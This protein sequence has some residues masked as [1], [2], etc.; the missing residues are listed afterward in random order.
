MALTV[1]TVLPGAQYRETGELWA[2]GGMN[3]PQKPAISPIEG[4]NL[5][6]VIVEPI[7]SVV[8]WANDNGQADCWPGRIN[9]QKGGKTGSEMS[10][11]TGS[12][13]RVG[14]STSPTLK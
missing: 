13:G 5:F 6:S 10:F 9:G 11:S 14:L 1:A 7:T 12:L 2:V 3:E 4:K 8:K